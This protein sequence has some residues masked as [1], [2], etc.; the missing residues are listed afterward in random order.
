MGGVVVSEMKKTSTALE[1]KEGLG[2]FLNPL[3]FY[4]L[5]RFMSQ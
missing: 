5:R 4:E 1:H 3:H 2:D